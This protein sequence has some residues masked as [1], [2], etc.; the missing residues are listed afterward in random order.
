MAVLPLSGIRIVDAGVVVMAEYG[1]YIASE[2][3]RWA[4]VVKATGA[5]LE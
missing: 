1:S 2:L 3:D 4:R 5:S